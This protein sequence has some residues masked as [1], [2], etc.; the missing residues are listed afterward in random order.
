MVFHVAGTFDVVR[1][2]GAALELLE[3]RAQRFR[4]DIS[5]DIETATVGHAHGNLTNTRWPPRLMICSSAG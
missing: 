5:E 3:N 1:L 4:H 2:E